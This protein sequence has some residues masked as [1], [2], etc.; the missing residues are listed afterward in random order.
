MGI[1]VAEQGLYLL[2]ARVTQDQARE[3]AWEQKLNIFG[4]QSVDIGGERTRRQA[5]AS[6]CRLS[7]IA[8]PP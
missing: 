4:V 5:D 1:A 6:H 7:T 8:S 2:P 3:K